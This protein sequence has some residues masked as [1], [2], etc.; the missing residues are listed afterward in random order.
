MQPM[1]DHAT[2]WRPA[3]GRAFGQAP[4]TIAASPDVALPLPPAMVPAWLRQDRRGDL[5]CHA[6]SMMNATHPKRAVSLARLLIKR[7]A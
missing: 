6:L 2:G 5:L 4:F 1:I 3:A 7:S